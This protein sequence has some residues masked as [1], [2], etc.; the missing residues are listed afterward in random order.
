MDRMRGVGTIKRSN[1]EKCRLKGIWYSTV[2]RE[3]VPR[4][5]ADSRR[6]KGVLLNRQISP[7]NESRVVKETKSI[8]ALGLEP[9]QAMV[10]RVVVC[11][12]PSGAFVRKK[13]L[14]QL[15]SAPYE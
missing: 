12:I 9:S 7:P 13:P 15:R 8:S 10:L 11:I 14:Q 6:E 5:S 2:V 1:R 4:E 3:A